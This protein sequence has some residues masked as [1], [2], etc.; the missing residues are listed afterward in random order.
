MV[1]QGNGRVIH[2]DKL[3]LCNP[4]FRTLPEDVGEQFQT[5]CEL[6]S[7]KSGGQ[8]FPIPMDI[9]PH[10]IRWKQVVVRYRKGDFRISPSEWASMKEVAQFVFDW[11]CR[12]RG[13]PLKNFVW[14]EGYAN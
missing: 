10:F 3:K 8:S 14:D 13:Q 6:Y 5:V 2:R 4:N 9:V 12:L 11:H 1:Y 7:R